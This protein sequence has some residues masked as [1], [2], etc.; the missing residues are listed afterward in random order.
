MGR[1]RSSAWWRDAKLGIFIHWTPAS[2]P[3]YAPTGNEVGVRLARRDHDALAWMPYTEWYENSLRFDASPA[4]RFHAEHFRG[5]T[6]ESFVA[7][8]ED[9]LSTW[10]PSAW[11]EQFS[12]A[13]AR[14]VVL[15][16]KHHDGY[17]LWPTEVENPNKLSFHSRRD[18]VGE[19]ATAVRRR[20]M[21][22][23]LYYSGGLDWTFDA[24]PIGKASDL[25]VAQPGGA[26]PDYAE[27]QVREL[28]DRYQPSILWNDISWPTSISRLARLLA[29][30]YT[31]VP[32][33]VVNDR[34]FPRTVPWKLASAAALRP[35]LDLAVARGSG[36]DQGLVPPRAPFFDVRTPEYTSFPDLQRTPWESVRGIDHSFGFNRASGEAHFLTKRDL[37]WSFTDIVAKGGNLLLN[38]G[39]RGEDAQIPDTQLR[40]LEWLGHFARV[41]G[42]SLFATRPWV[43][44]SGADATG[45]EVRYTTRADVVYAL[46]RARSGDEVT[47]TVLLADVASTPTTAVRAVGSGMLEFDTTDHG[48]VV[49]LGHALDPDVPVALELRSVTAAGKRGG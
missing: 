30:Y 36:G 7:D 49:H 8:W 20:G 14:Y 27:A 34:F 31:A 48:L 3:G 19:L 40:R 4:A 15:V 6:Y 32:D 2:V 33:G 11:V 23:G 38:V 44:A 26:Y 24:H 18:V 10:D 21:R 13:G 12:S 46:L 29:D 37:L 41:A 1:G 42:S 25:L 16:A 45:P 22:F 28:I 47:R 39:P 17:C 35:L 43:V 9:G 5:R